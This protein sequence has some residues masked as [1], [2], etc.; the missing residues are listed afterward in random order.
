MSSFLRLS[1]DNREQLS[2]WF[3]NVLMSRTPKDP[4]IYMLTQNYHLKGMAA[5]TAQGKMCSSKCFKNNSQL[6]AKPSLVEFVENYFSGQSINQHKHK[7][8]VLIWLHVNEFS[9]S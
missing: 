4:H 9:F 5:A 7:H 8:M 2:Q 1:V 6:I 3:S